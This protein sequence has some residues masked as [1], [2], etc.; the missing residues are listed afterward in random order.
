MAQI[1]VLSGLTE[2]LQGNR[3]DFM[4]KIITFN[5]DYR[6][7]LYDIRGNPVRF[8]FSSTFGFILQ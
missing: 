7:K 4:Q 6:E 3:E 1:R 8:L 5:T 2:R